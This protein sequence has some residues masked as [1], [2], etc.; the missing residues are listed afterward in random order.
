MARRAIKAEA[1]VDVN[2]GDLVDR[3]YVLDEEI[4]AKE[5][6][7]KAIKSKL[8][9]IAQKTKN[10]ILGG[11]VHSAVFSSNTVNTINPL[12]F[13]DAMKAKRN[14]PGFFASITVGNTN[15]KEHMN[16][17]DLE[18]I[19]TSETNEYGKISFK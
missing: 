7:L 12:M 13:F 1:V 16:E 19:T 17:F 14:L 2:V 5:K 3:G 11:G 9:E 4:K 18:K 15:A 10:K 6:E 8:K